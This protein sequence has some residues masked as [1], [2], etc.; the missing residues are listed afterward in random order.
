M[1]NQF[2]HGFTLVRVPWSSPFSRLHT[3]FHVGLAIKQ[4]WRRSSKNYWCFMQTKDVPRHTVTTQEARGEWV[5]FPETR[6][7]HFWF[8]TLLD[9][10]SNFGGYRF[11]WLWVKKESSTRITIFWKDVSFYRTVFVDVPFSVTHSQATQI[12]EVFFSSYSFC[13]LR[14]LLACLASSGRN[15]RKVQIFRRL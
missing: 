12:S 11:G 5:C 6:R 7:C 13:R 9:P 8:S 15:Q 3:P 4:N 1:V 2:W 10:G 14:F